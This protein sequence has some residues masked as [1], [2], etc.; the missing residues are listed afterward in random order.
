MKQTTLAFYAAA[1]GIAAIAAAP[2]IAA[3]ITPT[4]PPSELRAWTLEPA[5]R[6]ASITADHYLIGFGCGPDRLTMTAAAEDH[7]PDHEYNADGTI[8]RAGCEAIDPVEAV[9]S[10]D[11]LYPDEPVAAWECARYMGDGY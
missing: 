1:A 2:I 5:G 8:K 9:C 11:P 4:D 3:A 6:A 7:F 10:P